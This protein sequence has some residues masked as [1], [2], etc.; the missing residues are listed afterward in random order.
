MIEDIKEKT[1]S[2]K[3]KSGVF[4]DTTRVTC[5]YYNACQYD[6]CAKHDDP[7]DYIIKN[8]NIIDDAI[9]LIVACEDKDNTFVQ[10]LIKL[11]LLEESDRPYKKETIT[12]EIQINWRD[13]DSFE[14]E[15]TMYDKNRC[16][17]GVTINL[18]TTYKNIKNLDED[19]LDKWVFTFFTPYGEF[20]LY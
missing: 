19:A 17:A 12:A 16:D 18:E 15:L 20:E 9:S 13:I 4:E 8:C 14:P 6:Y 11:N 5:E 1:K 2:E 10:E 3:I 7:L